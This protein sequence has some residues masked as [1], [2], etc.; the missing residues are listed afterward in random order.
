M[1]SCSSISAISS[2]A[3]SSFSMDRLLTTLDWLKASESLYAWSLGLISAWS[4][5]NWWSKFSSKPGGSLVAGTSQSTISL[6]LM[7]SFLVRNLEKLKLGSDR[8]LF[9]SRLAC[10]S[11]ALRR[12]VNLN[13]LNSSSSGYTISHST[14]K[15]S[16]HRPLC[17]R[18][19]H[20]VL[21]RS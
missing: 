17:I 14:Q 13:F 5:S 11:K 10:C 18:S 2:Q 12:S 9:R 21:K 1:E 4:S 20:C 8:V 3:A 19:S 6:C 15:Y 7:L 16:S